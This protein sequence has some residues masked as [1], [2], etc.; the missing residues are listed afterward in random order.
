MG[1]ERAGSGSGAL[2]GT[3]SEVMVKS[4]AKKSIVV[5]VYV[6]CGTL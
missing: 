3:C 4:E 2:E 1:V 6:V 5:N